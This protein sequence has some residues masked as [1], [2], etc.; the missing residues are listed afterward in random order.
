MS[1]IHTPCHDLQ[2]SCMTGSTANTLIF[3][4]T[5]PKL[6]LLQ[7]H[8]SLSFPCAQLS[9]IW[10]IILDCSLTACW[11]FLVLNWHI[12]S[13]RTSLPIHCTVVLPCCSLSQHPLLSFYGTYHC[14][15]YENKDHVCVHIP[16]LCLK[17]SSHSINICWMKD[18]LVL[19]SLCYLEM[20]ANIQDYLP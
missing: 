5:L 6:P 8:W 14:K 13:G 20:F 9:H 16:E 12:P 2:G 17:H 18:Q 15:L 19:L 10:L 3:L 11:L 1:I 7:P 4:T